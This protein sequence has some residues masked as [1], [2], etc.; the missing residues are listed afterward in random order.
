M[1]PNVFLLVLNWNM[2]DD[3]IE[4]VRSLQ[5]QDYDNFTIVIID[6]ASEDNSVS[7]LKAEFSDIKVI[8][9]KDNLG[10]A[11]GNNI[12]IR[13]ALEEG[14]DYIFILNNDLTLKKDCLRRL[15]TAGERMPKSGMLAPKVCYYDNPKMINSLG[16]SIDWFRLRPYLGSCN[17]LDDGQFDEIRSA[18]ILVGCAL[19]VKKSVIEK[20]GLLDKDFF[21]LHEDSDWCLRGLRAG[22]RNMVIPEAMA[23]HKASKTLRKFSALATYYSIRNFLYLSYKNASLLNRLKVFF[24]LVYLILKNAVLLVNRNSQRDSIAFFCGITD[25]MK[26]AMGKCRRGF[27]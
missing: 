1:H 4:C 13:Y 16:T 15:V 18:D 27:S 8:V 22:Y 9:N 26:R 20:I 21:M 5:A 12:G 2:P 23:F 25:Y 14:A 3:T 10:F 7:M 24:G 11:E 19:M 17:Q 6:N